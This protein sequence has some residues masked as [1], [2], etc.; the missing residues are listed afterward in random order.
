MTI[1]QKIN[2]FMWHLPDNLFAHFY[3]DI[4]LRRK[5]G[6]EIIGRDGAWLIGEIGNPASYILSPTPK[7]LSVK[8]EH[9]K[10]KLERHFP[11]MPGDT[12]LD[13]GACIG[14]TTNYMAHQANGGSVYAV[15]PMP[16]NIK[17]LMANVG[18]R[19]NTMI[20]KKAAWS[21]TG[22]MKLYTHGAIT[23]HSLVPGWKRKGEITVQADTIDNM[24]GGIKVDYAKIDVQGSELEVLT[25]ADHLLKTTDRLLVECHYRYL[26]NKTYPAVIS[27]LEDYRY[28][29]WH[30][31]DNGIVYAW[32]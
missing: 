15:E 16:E 18:A 24:F 19:P 17:F 29:T 5:S 21:G 25:G 31:M 1:K 22:E 26:E 4:I 13:V 10:N 27:Q 23:G 9:F 11:I 32:R 28:K 8:W 3:G 2:D 20:I 6:I 12:V 30:E 7:F 14:D